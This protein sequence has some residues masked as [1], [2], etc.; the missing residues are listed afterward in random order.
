[1]P[2]SGESSEPHSTA[3]DSAGRAGGAGVEG[4]S[5]GP[6]D[7]L[8]IHRGEVRPGVHLAWWRE[9]IGGKPLLLVHGWPET[10][11]IWERNVLPLA[12]A[13]FEVIV[14]DLRGFGDSEVAADGFQDLA[15]HSRD[16]EALVR[17]T[18]GHSSCFA[19]GG[20][21]GGGVVQ[22]MSLRF[23][24]LISR[25]IMFNTILPLLVDDYEKAGLPRQ[26]T[27]EVRANAGYF[28]RQGKDADGLC[29]ELGGPEARASYVESFYTE[30]GWAAAGAV[31]K[32]D[33]ARMARPFMDAEKFRDGLGNYE[34]ALGSRP[35]SEMPI[36]F[37]QNLTPTLVL[38]G[39]EDHVIPKE[40]PQ[41][42]EVAFPN[43]TGPEFVPGAGHFLQW[44]AAD[45]FN[46]AAMKFPDR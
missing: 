41:M 34:S 46:Q 35:L 25:Q 45:R 10:K 29:S 15:A 40:F 31:P 32:A 12:A 2:G 38:Y 4:A 43:R 13:G 17:G 23:P 18:L 20:D 39:P 7:G 21:L 19:A 33:A 36:F 11:L 3:S 24:G 30:R 22:D 42:C 28:A 8:K 26:P 44:E 16:L 14:P 6:C 27:D 5:F 9:G 1:M 37:E